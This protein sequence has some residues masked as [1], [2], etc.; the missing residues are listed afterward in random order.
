MSTEKTQV[1]NSNKNEIIELYKKGF[2]INDISDKLN[3]AVI[4][5]RKI[6]NESGFETKDYRKCSQNNYDKAILLV[7]AGYPHV[8]VASLLNISSHLLREFVS[9][10]GLIGYSPNNPVPVKLEDK[11]Y[12]VTDEMVVKFKS[13][14]LSGTYGLAKCAQELELSDDDFLW[15][16]YHLSQNEKKTHQEKLCSNIKSTYMK[17]KSVNYVAKNLDIS[18][19]VVKK[20]VQ[21]S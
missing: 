4:P 13:L 14:Y 15:I 5:I 7:R 21:A 17:E 6:L 19:A 10:A 16:V 11:I 20:I 12:T 3:L 2:S 9:R 8:Q 18:L 1:Y